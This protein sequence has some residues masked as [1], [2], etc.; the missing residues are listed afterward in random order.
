[1]RTEL[2]PDRQGWSWGKLHTL[3]YSHAL[4]SVPVLAKLF[5]RGPYP[6]GGDSST[7]WATG[8]SFHEAKGGNVI[9]PPFRFIADVGDWRN[10][11]GLLVPGQ[12]GNPASPHYDDQV[13]AWFTGEY[14]PMWWTRE[15]VEREAERR[16][17]LRPAVQANV[18]AGRV[19]GIR[20][21]NLTGLCSTGSGLTPPNR[22][23]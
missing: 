4:S 3:T 8:A 6:L 14:H 18:S 5:N 19:F 13:E 15:D 23:L 9:A 20:C 11:L 1:L 7:I 21:M 2:G 17:E 16:L 22:Y 12:S 10:C